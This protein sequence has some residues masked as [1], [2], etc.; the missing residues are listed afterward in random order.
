M[1]VRPGRAGSGS[2]C[3]LADT[4]FREYAAVSVRPS[5]RDGERQDGT[6]ER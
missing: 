2:C 4:L 5:R 1:A 6:V 3:V